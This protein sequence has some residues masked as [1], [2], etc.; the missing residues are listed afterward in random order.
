MEEIDEGD[1][2]SD[3]DE[4]DYYKNENNLINYLKLDS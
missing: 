4:E 2:L 1:Y 3:C